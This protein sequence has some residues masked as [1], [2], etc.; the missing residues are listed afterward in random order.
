MGRVNCGASK[1]NMEGVLIFFAMLLY[2]LLNTIY[3]TIYFY[4]FPII[5][6]CLLF[7]RE[8]KTYEIETVDLWRVVN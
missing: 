1:E 8:A 3:I 2:K 7:L 5:A 6:I 4:F